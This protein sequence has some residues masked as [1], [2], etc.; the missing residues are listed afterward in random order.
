MSPTQGHDADWIRNKA[1]EA[2]LISAGLYYDENSEQ[3]FFVI[4]YILKSDRN[5]SSGEIWLYNPDFNQVGRWDA[6]GLT[7]SPTGVQHTI[8]I[9]ISSSALF[10]KD[11]TYWVVLFFK[12][13]HADQYKNHQI[14]TVLSGYSGVC[15]TYY[16]G[17]V[18]GQV[19]YFE[20]LWPEELEEETT[21]P[22]PAEAIP[23]DAKECPVC[24]DC[25][26]P[27]VVYN[28]VHYYYKIILLV[29]IE[30]K[31]IYLCPVC[32][33]LGYTTKTW[34]D[35][36]LSLNPPKTTEV[37]TRKI[38]RHIKDQVNALANQIIDKATGRKRGCHS[39]G[40]QTP[41]TLDGNWIPDHF[42]AVALARTEFQLFGITI[43]KSNTPEW[44]LLPHCLTCSRKQGPK[45]RSIKA[46]VKSWKQECYV[47][48]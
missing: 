38:P 15:E 44:Y 10:E 30:R 26:H 21:P 18:D 33:A 16:S 27:G 1:L 46:L 7:A 3:E 47:I 8:F 34:P 23:T 39:C 13:N 45:I 2:D 31:V 20:H 24:K 6:Y 17:E 41:G 42:P 48:H 28:G 29:L 19:V 37:D 22:A 25:I 32:N 5:A 11:G 4:E 35:N 12:D 40:A 14:K 9:P 43:G 36:K